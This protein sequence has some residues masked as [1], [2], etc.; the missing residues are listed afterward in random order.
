MKQNMHICGYVDI[1]NLKKMVHAE[2]GP[3][4]FCCELIIKEQSDNR[5]SEVN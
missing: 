1:T 5:N 3:A 2:E 4:A